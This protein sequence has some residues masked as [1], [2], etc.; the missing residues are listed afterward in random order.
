M[1]IYI[2]QGTFSVERREVKLKASSVCDK[3]PSQAKIVCEVSWTFAFSL[4]L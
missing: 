3:L 2:K 1:E 4:K